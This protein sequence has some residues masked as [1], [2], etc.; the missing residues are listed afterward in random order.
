[1]DFT[2]Y[3]LTDKQLKGEQ[4][5]AEAVAA[6][7][8]NRLEVSPRNADN[9][10][11]FK[12]EI[13]DALWMLTRQWQ[14]G[15]FI[16]DDAGS[17][18]FTNL[19]VQCNYLGVPGDQPLEA[20]VEQ[21]PVFD[22]TSGRAVNLQWRLQ[23]AYYWLKLLDKNGLSAEA[24]YFIN[25]P[26]YQVKLPADV[27]QERDAVQADALA[28]GK[29]FDGWA[30][31]NDPNRF[32][33]AGPQ[34]AAMKDLFKKL[35]AWYARHIQQPQGNN[36]HW[37][38]GNLEYRFN[39]TLPV[40]SLTGNT[41]KTYELGTKEYYQGRLDWYNFGI[42]RTTAAGNAAK[43]ADTIDYPDASGRNLIPGPVSFDGMPEKRYWAIEDAH[44]NFAAVQP[45][46]LDL[47][48]MA[49]IEFA[50][51][52]GNDWN[53]VPLKAPVGSFLQVKRLEV[54]DSFGKRTTIPFMGDSLQSTWDNFRFFTL[55]NATP[56]PLPGVL[57]PPA[58]G[59]LQ[60]GKPVEEVVFIRDEVANLVWGIETIVPGLLGN[61]ISGREAGAIAQPQ[62]QGSALAYQDQTTVPR[63]WIPFIAVQHPNVASKIVLRRGSMLDGANQRIRPYTALLR[64]GIDASD[65][66]VASYDIDENE[67]G[68]EGTVVRKSYQ[69]TRWT[70][71][72]V[73]LWLGVQ[74]TAGKGEGSSALKFDQLVY[75]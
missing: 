40:K 57:L 73:C 51:I 41:V 47:G 32:D 55:D 68:R 8:W 54:T 16:G 38:P 4:P 34:A 24:G 13:W 10:S 75:K 50:L 35:Q 36:H 63:N 2:K 7:V 26:G 39:S 21:Q 53:L 67:I 72:E 31:Y 65:N 9:T 3:Q 58:V 29:C 43:P 52:Y 27:G 30:F 1:M 49:L 46:K 19:S 71:G 48:K 15:E 59:M 17:L 6:P 28:K 23:I 37:Q 45:D 60:H 20:M 22:N 61:G 56:D 44:T 70:N 33:N 66:Q 14:L 5:I 69:R 11:A 62:P 74:K 64:N 42:Q 25:H 12:A 18:A